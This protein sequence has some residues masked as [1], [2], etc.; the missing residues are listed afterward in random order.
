M[1]GSGGATQSSASDEVDNSPS[2]PKRSSFRTTT[3]ISVYNNLSDCRDGNTVGKTGAFN[4]QT[5]WP[6]NVGG[7]AIPAT[8]FMP[9]GWSGEPFKGDPQYYEK[10]IG[11]SGITL[12][13]SPV[14]PK[15]ATDSNYCYRGDKM[16]AAFYCVR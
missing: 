5:A 10:P 9:F 11:N 6:C 16:N 14:G 4:V 8:L 2:V 15:V 7:H 12:L 3:K 1:T 13:R